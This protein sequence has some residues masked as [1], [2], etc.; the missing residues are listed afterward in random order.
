MLDVGERGRAHT[1]QAA[2]KPG[3]RQPVK[4][5]NYLATDARCPVC[6]HGRVTVTYFHNGVSIYCSGMC[7]ETGTAKTIVSCSGLSDS[8]ANRQAAI[9][10]FNS[11]R[12]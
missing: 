9:N 6:K 10:L 2:M 5:G 3:M 11:I 8:G 7:M 4:T 12:P 1:G